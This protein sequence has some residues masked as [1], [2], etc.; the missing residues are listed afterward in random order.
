[1][2]DTSAAPAAEAIETTTTPT[3][4]A[5]SPAPA[6]ETATIPEQAEAI[7]PETDDE[8]LGLGDAEGEEPAEQGEE[9]E[10]TERTPLKPW[11]PPEGQEVHEHARPHLQALDGI[12][13]DEKQRDAIVDLY[14]KM[15]AEQVMRLAELNTTT[16]A[17][18]VKALRGEL[19]ANFDAY[20]NQVDDAFKAL[21]ADFRAELKGARLADGRLLL[22]TRAGVD[23][24]HRLGAKPA[25]APSAE[26][27]RAAI[28][29]ELDEI[30]TAMNQDVANLYKPWKATGQLAT[31]RKL[32]L[33]RELESPKPKAS[34]AAL[35]NE[36]AELVGLFETDPMTFEYAPW[37][38]S[39]K[40]AAQRLY[41]L[42]RGR[43]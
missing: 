6:P 20:R 24:L 39:N 7:A 17:E 43:G 2:T 40:T 1:M 18:T 38:G 25:P 16:K 12:A 10:Q 8:G 13:K 41:E 42:R 26:D 11:A 15:H 3:P 19:G 31:D 35:R 37:K 4:A 34:A 9:A 29:R 32:S 21:P 22:S 36:E 14:N 33:M 30:E 23:L 27:R 5:P 28:Q